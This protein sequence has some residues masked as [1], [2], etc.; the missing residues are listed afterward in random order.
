MVGLLP[1]ISDRCVLFNGTPMQHNEAMRPL[2]QP[3]QHQLIRPITTRTYHD[4]PHGDQTSR[5]QSLITPE[6][7]ESISSR[8]SARWRSCMATHRAVSSGDLCDQPG[9]IVRS[10]ASTSATCRSRNCS[11]RSGICSALQI[12][13]LR[14]CSLLRRCRL[15]RLSSKSRRRQNSNLHTQQ[16]TTSSPARETS[17]TGS[18]IITMVSAQRDKQIRDKLK[19]TA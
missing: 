3:T 5:D 11:R 14:A 12:N 19:G 4:Q 13:R 15:H 9:G 16:I 17:T 18:S 10:C 6:P 2:S 7:T 8:S 1:A